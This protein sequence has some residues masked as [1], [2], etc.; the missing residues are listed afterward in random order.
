[1]PIASN[2]VMLDGAAVSK[3]FV[4]TN[5]A[6]GVTGYENRASGNMAIYDV[7]SI[8]VR[9]S[10]AGGKGTRMTRVVCKVKVVQP[11]VVGI[12]ASGVTPPVNAQATAWANIEFML[13]DEMASAKVDDIYAFT[14]G[15]LSNASIKTAILQR[16]RP[17]A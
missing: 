16:D 15:F 7:A 8:S 11:Q 4:P 2:V 13:P 5:L 9:R 6:E 14:V 17:T 3:T 10:R 12:A 1:M